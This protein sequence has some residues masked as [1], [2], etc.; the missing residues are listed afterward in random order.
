MKYTARI[1]GMWVGY[2]ATRTE[3]AAACKSMLVKLG[4]SDARCSI[5]VR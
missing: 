4:R 2:F 5:E 1:E 3:A